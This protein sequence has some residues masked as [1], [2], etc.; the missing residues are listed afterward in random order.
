[1][2]DYARVVDLLSKTDGRDKIYKFSAGVFKVLGELAEQQEAKGSYKKMGASITSARSLMRM[3]KFIGDGPK[4]LKIISTAQKGGL[5][6]LPL[7]K[8][9]EFFRVI[10]NSLYIMGDNAAF[11]AK[12]KVLLTSADPKLITKGAK[13]AQ[14]WG[15]FLAAVLDLLA[16]QVALK[17]RAA[18]PTASCAEGKAAL[19][20]LA[21]DLSDTLVAIGHRRLP[22]RDLAPHDAHLR[23]AH[24]R[25]RWC[26]HVPQLGE[27]EEE[28]DAAP[29]IATYVKDKREQENDEKEREKRNN[30]KRESLYSMRQQKTVKKKQSRRINN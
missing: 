27:D 16:L 12:H 22:A 8:I 24:L 18:D 14:F 7:A 20:A 2:S 15:F 4:L 3:G 9:I 10:G 26:G 28:V 6:S 29:S 30:N 23:R 5:Q 1:M 11:F 19:M 17:K 25:V 13:I 21:K